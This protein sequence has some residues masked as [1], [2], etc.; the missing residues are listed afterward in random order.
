MRRKLTDDQLR[1]LIRARITKGDAFRLTTIPYAVR[2]DET[3]RKLESM[4]REQIM[5]EFAA[6]AYDVR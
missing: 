6:Y 5:A 1:D 4:T 3:R 2:Q